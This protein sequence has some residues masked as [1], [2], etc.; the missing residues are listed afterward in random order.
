MHFETL[1]ER[2]LKTS[3]PYDFL[4]RVRHTVAAATKNIKFLQ[5][6]NHRQQ[7]DQSHP[8]GMKPVGEVSCLAGGYGGMEQ[9]AGIADAV[10]L[11]KMLARC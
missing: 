9:L 3:T 8:G 11:A 2:S 1:C 5:L 7:G 6:Q 10:G 4:W